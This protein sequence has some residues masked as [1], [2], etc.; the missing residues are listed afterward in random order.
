MFI[1]NKQME[2]DQFLINNI[3]QM[4]H[5]KMKKQEDEGYKS[6]DIEG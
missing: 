3:T 4:T 5:D 6:N 2:N 1:K